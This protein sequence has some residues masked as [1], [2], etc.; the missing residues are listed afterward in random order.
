MSARRLLL[1][2][3]GHSHL[4]VLR[5]F[6]AL[7]DPSIAI[8]LVSARPATIY[9]GMLPG[10]IAGHYALTEAEVALAPLAAA[11]GARWIEG[12]VVALDLAARTARLASGE[13]I[14]FDVLSLNLGST[15]DASIPGAGEHA[16]AARPFEHLVAAWTEI[17]QEATRDGTRTLA[18]VGGGAGGVE[19]V[20]AMHHR[21]QGLGARGLQCSLVTE[22]ASLL[23]GH[24]QGVGA[25]LAR[26]LAQRGIAVHL[27]SRV[28]AIEH[29]ALRLESG[30]DIAAWRIFLATSAAA[31]AWWRQGGL[32][33]DERGFISVDAQLRSTTHPFVFAAGDCASQQGARHPKS[34]LHAVRQG[35]V[36]AANLARCMAGAPL[37]RFVPPA[38]WL[39]LIGTGDERAVVSYGP[40]SAEGAWAWRW[41]QSIDRRH[42]AKYR[43]GQAARGVRRDARG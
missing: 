26:I 42:V 5:R 18:V 17:L 30:R 15:P 1:A 34:G 33:C 7:K 6:A 28:R 11:A 9:S 29:G 8:T 37:K 14:A 25:R 23:P 24:A 12:R 22:G 41:K 31:A 35:P 39:A 16:V 21:L 32:G 10:V 2:G 36:L 43:A 27:Q 13:S 38:R 40:V 3:G 20:L 4:E 19:L